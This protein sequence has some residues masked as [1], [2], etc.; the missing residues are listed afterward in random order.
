MSSRQF[1]HFPVSALA[2][3][4]HK[5]LQAVGNTL[6]PSGVPLPASLLSGSL[7]QGIDNHIS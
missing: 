5:V 1:Y 7:L 6:Y 3:S 4:L 2:T